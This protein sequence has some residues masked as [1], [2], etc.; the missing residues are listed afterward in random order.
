MRALQ[1][2][3][4]LSQANESDQAV[5]EILRVTNLESVF[6]NLRISIFDD[7]HVEV[8]LSSVGVQFEIHRP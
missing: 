2:A 6:K 7:D 8:A 5:R 1:A 4:Y 3:G